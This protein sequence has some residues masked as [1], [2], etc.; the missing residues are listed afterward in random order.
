MTF[1]LSTMTNSV[2]SASFPILVGGR[3]LVQPAV[4]AV[5]VFGRLRLQANAAS[6]ATFF[7]LTARLAS[8][9]GNGTYVNWTYEWTQPGGQIDRVR[10]HQLRLPRALFTRPQVFRVHQRG[11]GRHRNPQSNP[12]PATLKPKAHEQKQKTKISTANR[13]PTAH[14]RTSRTSR[15]SSSSFPTAPPP[16][17]MSYSSSCAKAPA[18]TLHARETDPPL[19]D[20]AL[21]LLCHPSTRSAV[22]SML[23]ECKH[24]A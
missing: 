7:Q 23:P 5:H 18:T 3:S 19:P 16:T 2:A 14:Q 13:H 4:A 11:A 10:R 21:A 15:T 9:M 22:F 24:S 8:S 1:S 17:T 6:Q 20:P 12:P